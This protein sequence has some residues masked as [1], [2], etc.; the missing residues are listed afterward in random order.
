[1]VKAFDEKQLYPLLVQNEFSKIEDFLNKYGLDSVDSDGRTI[2]ST[3]IV[4][5]KNNFAK[6]IIDL[7]ADINQ[8]DHIGYSPFLFA[9]SSSNKELLL[10]FLK[11]PKLDKTVQNKY[12]KNALGIALQAHPN[13]NE[14]MLLLIDS[15]IDPFMKYFNKVDSPYSIMKEFESGELTIGNNKLNI[16][17][18]VQKIENLYQIG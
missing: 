3:A 18:V 11:N 16:E 9:V 15:G 5:H 6:K 7:G 1:M 2:L 10:E 13:D 12:G 14:L 8:Q 17:P 4:E